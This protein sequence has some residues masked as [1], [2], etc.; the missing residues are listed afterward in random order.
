[1]KR[2]FPDATCW[3]AAAGSPSGG[4]AQILKLGRLGR[5]VIVTSQR[6]LQEAEKNIREAFGAEGL[7]RFYQDVADL[8]LEIVTEPT[9][10]DEAQWQEIT[11]AKDCHVLAAVFK[12][13]ADVLVTL[14]RRHLL[15]ETVEDHFPIPVMDTN[16]Q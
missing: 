1:M 16:K 4:S 7:G 15:T 3:V 13:G 8:E 2:V 11:A 9:P 5:L 10:E 14:D 12:A 6:V